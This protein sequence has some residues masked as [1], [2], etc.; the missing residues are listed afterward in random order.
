MPSA[1]DED[2]KAITDLF[3]SIDIAPLIRELEARG[4]QQTKDWCWKR[5]R[6]PNDFEWKLI[7]FLIEEWDFGGYIED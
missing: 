6:A 1:S 3:G 4:F 7:N 2:R 5:S